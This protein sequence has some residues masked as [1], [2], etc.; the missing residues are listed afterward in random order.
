MKRKWL[1]IGII[2]MFVGTCIIPAMA[3]DTKKTLPSSRGSWLYVGGSGPGNYTM[4]QDAIDNA[5]EGDTMFVFSGLYMEYIYVNISIIL[6]GENRGTTIID[7]YGIGNVTMINADNVMIS[8]FTLQHSGNYNLYGYSDSG[9][10]LLSNNNIIDGNIIRDNSGACISIRDSM[11]NAVSHNVIINSTY[12]G[13]ELLNS[14]NNRFENNTISVTDNGIEFIGSIKNFISNNIITSCRIASINFYGGS[15]NNIVSHNIL[16]N[17]WAKIYFD[18]YFSIWMCYSD[19][20]TFIENTIDNK[21][22]LRYNME[23]IE[24]S[25]N[26]FLNNNFLKASLQIYFIESSNNQWDGNYWGR[27]RLLPKIILGKNSHTDQYPTA[28]NFDMHPAKNPL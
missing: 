12:T 4:I 22:I 23:I 26:K 14:T 8:G 27:A 21:G 13:I 19:N 2:L 3:Q 15:N 5:S 10:F 18:G 28:F 16:K 1:A 11:N 7:A 24:C 9:V 6:L 20:N 25:N 17:E